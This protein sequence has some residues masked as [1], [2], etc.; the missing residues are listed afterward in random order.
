MGAE[1][2]LIEVE[3]QVSSEADKVSELQSRHTILEQKK[4][5]IEQQI[6]NAD[7]RGC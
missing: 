5:R 1:A 2:Q 3:G 6:I 4:K 7:S